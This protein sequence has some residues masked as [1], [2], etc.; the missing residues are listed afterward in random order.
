MTLSKAS[1]KEARFE[2]IVSS[3][4]TSVF[5]FDSFFGTYYSHSGVFDFNLVGLIG[6][7]KVKQFQ[8]G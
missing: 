7:L 8:P 2:C 3:A 1:F 5:G 6:Y 4:A